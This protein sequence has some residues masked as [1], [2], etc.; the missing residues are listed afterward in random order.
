MKHNDLEVVLLINGQPAKE[1]TD[2]NFEQEATKNEVSKYIEAIEG[3]SFELRYT[4]SQAYRFAPAIDWLYFDLSVDG[5]FACTQREYK[6]DSKRTG[7]LDCFVKWIDERTWE[8]SSFRFARLEVCG[9]S[10]QL[11]QAS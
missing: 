4:V 6:Q 9:K 7:L 10:S 3:A 2:A 8:K 1:Y 11:L 5:K